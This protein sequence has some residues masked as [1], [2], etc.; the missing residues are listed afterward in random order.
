MASVQ[1]GNSEDASTIPATPTV[2]NRK[3]WQL[4]RHIDGLN[5][6]NPTRVSTNSVRVAKKGGKAFLVVSSDIAE[7]TTAPSTRSTIGGS[8]IAYVVLLVFASMTLARFGENK[9]AI[10]EI[11]VG[12]DKFNDRYTGVESSYDAIP[13]PPMALT[14]E[15]PNYKE[16]E[17]LD[18]V[19]PVF[20][21]ND[22]N[23]GFTNRTNNVT[24][25]NDNEVDLVTK[26]AASRRVITGQRM[27]G[28]IPGPQPGR[29]S[30]SWIMRGS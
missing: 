3:H 2:L 27:E 13:M 12:G 10:S 20:S 5:G 4:L 7:V 18:Y 30:A 24:P 6:R 25:L 29:S 16:G 22:W 1:Q 26:L 21:W 17:L 28:W 15:V 19:W 14:I 8:L 11:L 9:P 23:N